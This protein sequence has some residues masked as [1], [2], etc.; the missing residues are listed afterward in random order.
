VTLL[1]LSRY[2]RAA[3]TATRRPLPPPPILRAPFDPSF[4]PCETL[5]GWCYAELAAIS[6]PSLPSGA[7]LGPPPPGRAGVKA[8]S[9]TSTV[10]TKPSAV[11]RDID[12]IPSRRSIAWADVVGYGPNPRECIDAVMR[13]KMVLLGNHDQGA[14]FDPEAFNRPAERAIFWTRSQLGPSAE[15]RQAARSAGSPRRTARSHREEATCTSTARSRANPLNEYVFPETSTTSG[16][17]E[18]IFALV[19][20]YCFQ[21]HTP[22]PRRLVEQAPTK[23][24]SVPQPR[25]VGQRLPAGRAARRSVTS[26]RRPARATATRAPAT[27]CFDANHPLPSRRVR[28]RTTIKKIYSIPISRTSRRP[29]PRRPLRKG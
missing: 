26:A 9:A 10:T 14:M 23:P 18:R 24:V 2:G 12:R 11:L 19:E 27:S 25:E 6:P 13:C 29:P 22:R 3:G 8:S 21:G 15:S 4:R 1:R 16:K 28:P 5:L 7:N 17:M 20:R